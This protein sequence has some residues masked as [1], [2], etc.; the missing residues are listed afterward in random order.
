MDFVSATS[1]K[2][3]FDDWL[4]SIGDTAYWN[5]GESLEKDTIILIKALKDNRE[6]QFRVNIKLT[7]ASSETGR[8]AYTII[9]INCLM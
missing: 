3:M 7:A 5:T 9:P 2:T 8:R 4:S 6:V 1:G